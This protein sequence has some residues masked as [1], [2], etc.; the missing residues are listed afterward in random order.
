MRK[1][2][3]GYDYLGL[4][5]RMSLKRKKFAD[6]GVINM[7]LIKKSFD[8]QIQYWKQQLYNDQ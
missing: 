4:G 3:T 6:Y 2:L 7:I 1:S 8:V 5:A